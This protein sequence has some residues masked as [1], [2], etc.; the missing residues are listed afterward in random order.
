MAKHRTQAAGEGEPHGRLDLDLRNPFEL[1]FDGVFD[2]DDLPFPRVDLRKAGIQGRRFAA[3]RRAGE[4]YDPVG[5]LQKPLKDFPFMPG[6]P[7][8]FEAKKPGG[9]QD[10]QDNALSVRRG[11][12]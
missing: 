12:K 2:G 11:Q 7:Q 1:V 5:F 4:K 9:I 10:P 8:F 6:K 3:S